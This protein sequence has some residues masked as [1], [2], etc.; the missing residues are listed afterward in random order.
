M[1]VPL[2][3]LFTNAPALGLAASDTIGGTVANDVFVGGGGNDTITGGTGTDTAVF[4]GNRGQYLIERQA[5]GTT[6]VTDLR[7]NSPD[8]VD[9]LSS[10]ERLQFANVNIENPAYGGV[11]LKPVKTGGERTMPSPAGDQSD[12]D[13]FTTD[14]GFFRI[15]HIDYSQ[16]SNGQAI[17]FFEF[18][19]DAPAFDPNRTILSVAGTEGVRVESS[20]TSGNAATI[21]LAGSNTQVSAASANDQ[22]NPAVADLDDGRTVIVWQDGD[23]LQGRFTIPGLGLSGLQFTV[24]TAGITGL[25]FPAVT[26]LE[27]SAYAVAYQADLGDG[28]EIYIKLF[29]GSVATSAAIL[30]N[31]TTIGTQSDVAVA[32]LL[33]GNIAVTWVDDSSGSGRISGRLINDDGSFAGGSFRST[34]T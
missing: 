18:T 16:G 25:G 34:P 24:T 6:R 12:G 9:L 23:S 11:C 27:G 19:S 10:V 30:V 17:T 7:A 26:A 4:S 5:D 8:G 14:G 3:N 29:D 2:A 31:E 28:T 20:A 15:L 32:T 13:L 1:L 22:L 21:K 33:N